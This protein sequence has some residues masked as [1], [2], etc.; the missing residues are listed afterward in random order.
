MTDEPQ[1]IRALDSRTGLDHRSDWLLDVALFHEKFEQ[2]YVGLPR[3]LSADLLLFRL[4]FIEEELRE[5]HDSA[6]SLCIEVNKNKPDP[7]MVAE[8]LNLNLDSLVDLMYVVLG[9]AYQ[10]GFF[11]VLEEAW[12][13]VQVAN[14]SK[15]K[16]LKGN[17]TEQESGRNPVYDVVKPRNF[18]PPNHYDLVTNHA[19]RSTMRLDTEEPKS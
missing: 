13:R 16:K 5:W 8:L 17:G 10:Q 4:K 14:M 15:I 18:V 11:P 7:W 9:T 2:A 1:S 3:A 6:I 19:H 12:R